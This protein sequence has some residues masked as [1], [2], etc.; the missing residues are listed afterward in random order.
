[1]ANSIRRTC[2]AEVPT[3]AIE[4][5]IVERNDTVLHD[6]FI[7]HRLGF[8]PLT[9]TQDPRLRRMNFRNVSC[10]CGISCPLCEVG[11][12]HALHPP[13]LTRA[14]WLFASDATC[15]RARA[16]ACVRIVYAC[17]PGSMCCGASVL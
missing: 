4:N 17:I 1:M 13:C 11:S 9:N 3:L 16:R 10:T 5:V 14:S 2:I 7:C 8:V 6:E 15:A 12:H